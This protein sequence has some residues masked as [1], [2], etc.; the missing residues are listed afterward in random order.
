MKVIELAGIGPGP[1]AGM[2]LADLGAEVI[3]LVRVGTEP[4][5][6]DIL[7]RG[8]SSVA[9]DLKHPEATDLVLEL[10]AGADV[11]I[12]GFRPGVTE[13]LGLGPEAC[14][15]ANPGLVYGRV[16]GWGQS[17]PQADMAG[18]DIDYIAATGALASIG[19]ALNPLPP[20]NLVGDFGG[21]SMLLVVGVLAAVVEARRTGRGQVVDAAMV[22]GSA[23]LMAMHHGALAGGWWEDGRARNLFDGSAPFYT[24]YPTSDGRFIAVGALEPHFY[25]DLLTKLGLDPEDLPS[26]MDRQGW[27]VLRERLAEVFAGRTMA[28]W[29]EVFADSDAC[30][31]G[32]YTMAEAPFHPQLAHRRTFIEV[33]GIRQPSP[34]PRFSRTP[35]AIPGPVPVPG[36]DTDSVMASLGIEAEAISRLRQEGV[37]A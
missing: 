24:T 34:A 27:H 15:A 13:R 12:E 9:I 23:L 30:V 7:N 3:Q 16:T 31:A 2:M 14:L 20:L 32:V 5:P 37:I 26:Q 4:D 6:S 36:R 35:T 33:G 18:H 25:A 21:G 8:K 28:E 29:E 22:D 10:V 1:H 17:G 11:L 19:P